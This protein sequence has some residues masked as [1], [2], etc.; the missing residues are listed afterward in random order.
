MLSVAEQCNCVVQTDLE[1]VKSHASH[2]ISVSST[3]LE[4][5]YS[6]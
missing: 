4:S 5:L 1:V 6:H 2:H 3:S